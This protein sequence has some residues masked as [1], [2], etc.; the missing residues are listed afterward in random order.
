MQDKSV[1]ECYSSSD[2]NN[3]KL[4]KRI[5]N[6]KRMLCKYSQSLHMLEFLH[7]LNQFSGL[8]L[9][10]VIILFW[11]LVFLSFM[12][13]LAMLAASFAIWHCT[14]VGDNFRYIYNHILCSKSEYFG[15][16]MIVN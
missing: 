9:E 3:S 7:L 13:V 5:K 10:F 8:V 15:V 4:Y 2:N 11:L 6:T 14:F 16:M 12:S 1:T